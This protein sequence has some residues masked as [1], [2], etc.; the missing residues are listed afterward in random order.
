MSAVGDP[1]QGFGLDT[2]WEHDDF[3]EVSKSPYNAKRCKRSKISVVHRISDTYPTIRRG[4]LRFIAR[5]RKE[6]W[7]WWWRYDDEGVGVTIEWQY[8]ILYVEPSGVGNMFV[9]V[10]HLVEILFVIVQ[11]YTIDWD[12]GHAATESHSRMLP[13]RSHLGTPSCQTSDTVW[14]QY[15]ERNYGLASYLVKFRDL[16]IMEFS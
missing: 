16:T 12:R 15:T 14:I 6:K 8:G 4:K 2:R 3:S 7:I 9:F 10:C 13:L 11:T 5:N 1:V